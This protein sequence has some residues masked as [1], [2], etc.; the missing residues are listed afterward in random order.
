MLNNFSDK[1][2]DSSQGEYE[3]QAL[4]G[5]IISKPQK[6]YMGGNDAGFEVSPT[7]RRSLTEGRHDSK[8]ETGAKMYSPKRSSISETRKASLS[9][10]STAEPKMS[11]S[12]FIDDK[13][14]SL[15]RS[16]LETSTK[17]SKRDSDYDNRGP[18]NR[19][20]SFPDRVDL[21]G[22]RGG[23]GSRVISPR[24]SAFNEEKHGSAIK[25]GEER[26]YSQ[27][28]RKYIDGTM[29]PYER[30]SIKSV[31]ILDT[32]A[33][34]SDTGSRIYLQNRVDP[35][36]EFFSFSSNIADKDG[37]DE[38]NVTSRQPS[39]ISGR[40]IFGISGID[41]SDDPRDFFDNSSY[42]GNIK[43]TNRIDNETE[44]PTFL[45]GTVPPK[46]ISSFMSRTDSKPSISSFRQVSL[47]ASKREPLDDKSEANKRSFSYYG[48]NR[49]GSTYGRNESG[50]NMRSSKG[51]TYNDVKSDYTGDIGD[52]R[53]IG[54]IK[55]D[56]FFDTR[57]EDSL[58]EDKS[59]RNSGA[60]Y[61]FEDD[62]ASYSK[63]DKIIQSAPHFRSRS[64]D[65]DIAYINK[66]ISH[67]EC[68]KGGKSKT[69]FRT[70][71]VNTDY[72]F[73]KSG[74]RGKV[75]KYSDEDDSRI[76]VIGREI[77]RTLSFIYEHELIP[78]QHVITGLKE[79]IDVL[80]EQQVM[81]REKLHGPK[82][83][84]P[85]KKCGC[86]KRYDFCSILE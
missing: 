84:R 54:V 10:R 23:S 39:T 41:T 60:Y 42:G 7:K 67:E 50:T 78:L 25:V 14:K 59:G 79:D 83:V 74:S 64:M 13:P 18:S 2:S 71:D 26:R 76:A 75:V 28:G 29:S 15:D 65:R 30:N 16:N 34:R 32:S 17:S 5:D 47:S 4:K 1:I 51:I 22:D 36:S 37:N 33:K 53:S 9:T 55:Y 77:N 58:I 48:E 73:S 85:V 82:R 6:D 19:R 31:S 56:S 80:A 43:Y 52:D 8:S 12:T 69:Y 20:G 66:R 27:D 21:L 40:D 61:P 57:K 68:D 35:K 72:Q 86:F 46:R 11:S 70:I 3:A 45:D 38:L 49:S 44:T 62:K 81:L 24:N 63:A